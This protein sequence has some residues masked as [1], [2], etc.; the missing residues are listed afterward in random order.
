MKSVCQMGRET[1]AMAQAA[2]STGSHAIGH[3]AVQ[4]VCSAGANAIA[5]WCRL[6]M[7]GLC[8]AEGLLSSY[9]T[10]G[11]FTDAVYRVAAKFPMKRM[12]V[13][14]THQGPPF[15]V[16]EFLIQVERASAE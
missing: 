9:K 13:G 4:S 2:G 12:E 6:R 14:V 7:L 8:D 1:Q 11:D 15:D 10:D 16:E 5:V 3:S